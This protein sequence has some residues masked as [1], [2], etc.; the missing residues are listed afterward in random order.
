[1][2]RQKI[3]KQQEQVKYNNDTIRKSSARERKRELEARLLVSKSQQYG[4]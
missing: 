2:E 4:K 1:M 3:R